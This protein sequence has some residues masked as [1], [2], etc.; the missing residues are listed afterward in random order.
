MKLF[1]SPL[2]NR[3]AVWKLVGFV[4]WL[5]G[6]IMLPVVLN[7]TD[8]YLRFAILLW[9]TTLW[10][11]IWVMWIMNKHP[12]FN[13]SF[14]FWIRWAILWAWMN[15]VL[16]LFMYDKMVLLMQNTVFVNYSPFCLIIEWIIVWFVIDLIATKTVWDGKKLLK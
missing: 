2:V 8:L 10:A 7:V 3:I 15:F 12:V 5:L 4:F 9:Y 13:I 6:F 14:P 1:E 16:V 11:I